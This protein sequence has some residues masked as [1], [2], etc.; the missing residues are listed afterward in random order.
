MNEEQKNCYIGKYS[1]F[2]LFTTSMKIRVLIRMNISEEQKR[3]EKEKYIK[4]INSVPA[5]DCF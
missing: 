5:A 4:I 2:G 3:E 1:D